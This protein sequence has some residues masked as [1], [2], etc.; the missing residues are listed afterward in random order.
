M[1]REI[2]RKGQDPV[3]YSRV[4]EREMFIEILQ[5]KQTRLI[6]R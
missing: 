2:G 4:R 6:F 1:G 3:P 5:F